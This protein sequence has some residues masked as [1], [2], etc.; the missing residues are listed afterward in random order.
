MFSPFEGDPKAT[1]Y[2]MPGT[3]GWTNPWG[4]LPTVLWNPHAQANDA[5]FG[6]NPNG[7]GFN[8]AGS[9]NLVIV[10]EVCTNL[11]NPIWFPVA[12]N[13]LTS[14]SSDFRDPLWT[15]SPAR[16]YRFRAP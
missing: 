3:T 7:F 8:I 10:V 16:F 2:Y 15:N 13:T 6:V 14:G 1:I 11:G 12:T 9:S 4:D 5:T